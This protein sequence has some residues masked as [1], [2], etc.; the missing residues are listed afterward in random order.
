MAINETISKN[1]VNAFAQG[2]NVAFP[3]PYIGLLTSM[4]KADGSGF[5]EVSY[6][7]YNRVPINIKGI[8]GLEIMGEP[9]VETEYVP[10]SG[11]VGDAEDNVTVAHVKNQ[12]IIYFPEAET[13]AGGTAVGFGLFA[14][15]EGGDP[16]LW[17]TLKKSATISI[18]SVPMFRIDDFHLSVK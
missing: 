6:P 7:E 8:N 3:T 14:S 4:P 18:N 5:G 15:K 16:Y 10:G 13:G 12:E 9:Y 11:D 1:I 17:G 2:G